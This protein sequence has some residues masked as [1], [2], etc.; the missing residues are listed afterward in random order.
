M[1]RLVGLA[2]AAVLASCTVG[3]NYH[4]PR[5]ET[6]P[7]FSEASDADVSGAP[8]SDAVLAAWWTQFNDPE[9]DSLIG[10]ALKGNLDL[11]SAASRVGQSRQQEV[12]SGAAGLPHVAAN[13][14]A[15]QVNTNSHTFMLP[16]QLTGGQSA[17][18]ST[19]SRINLYSVGFDATWEVD[20]FGGVRRSVEAAKANTEAARWQQRDGEVS[21]T[22]EVANDYFT[23]R[24][25]QV[26]IALLQTQL[27]E[28]KDSFALIRARHDAGFVTRLDVNQQQTQVESTAAELPA[29]EAQERAMRHAL[30]VL[31]GE[32]PET[33]D[34]E[35]AAN[36]PL[37]SPPAS[38]PIGLPSDLLRRR[39]DIRTAERQLA[40][41]NANVGVAI[42]ALYPK[43]NLLGVAS[44]ASM[45]LDTLFN[46]DNGSSVGAGYATWSIFEGGRLRANIRA[47]K[48][49]RE[50]AL[51]AYKKAV[52]G[53]LQDVED[54]L[55]RYSTEREHQA[56]LQRALDASQN[57]LAIA[58]SQY[59]AGIVNYI[60]VLSAEA[61]VL[62]A[63]DQLTQSNAQLAQD[64]ASLFKALGGGW[65]R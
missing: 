57:S 11:Q 39:P 23:L 3:P 20:L 53:G 49:A 52:I 6:P 44:L 43:F 31:L 41:A 17:A 8:P 24:A 29:L 55:A 9:L 32:A 48:A 54:A 18:I 60:N 13:A 4:P 5:V 37:P 1:R 30:A 46:G 35:L 12:V 7:V 47:S 2:T 14:A 34:T 33:L 42:A 22:A 10:R 64:L 50:Q 65:A 21:L 59:A 16:S 27:E 38:L 19:P 51:L 56:A 63:D 15:A 36:A 62:R 58:K 25:D 61:A 40:A 28:Q 45:H 26:R